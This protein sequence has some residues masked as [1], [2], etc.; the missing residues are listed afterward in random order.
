MLKDLAQKIADN[1]HQCIGFHVLV[2]DE[3]AIVIGASNRERLGIFNEGA[4]EVIKNNK[5]LHH[6]RGYE[7]KL[8]GTK[9]GWTVPITL[10]NKILGAIGI[11]GDYEIV[12][13]YA[14]LV[15]KHAELML[16]QQMYFKSI[17]YSEQALQN[18]IQELLTHANDPDYETILINRG[19]ELGFDITTGFISISVT[20]NFEKSSPADIDFQKEIISTQIKQF[21]SHK[22]DISLP[23]ANNKFLI[24]HTLPFK[25]EEREL[26]EDVKKSCR[27]PY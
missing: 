7:K 14:R 8:E 15:R 18:F 24:L 23:M 25:Y 4:W 10:H 20:V 2:T 27:A 6:F 13:M 9:P 21:F 16:K 1:T 19:Q 3:N 22:N 11:T 5:P 12:E 26:E 17:L